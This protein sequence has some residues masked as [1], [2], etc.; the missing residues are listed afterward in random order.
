MLRRSEADSFI[1][2]PLVPS[3]PRGGSVSSR[4]SRQDHQLS[5][6]LPHHP[7]KLRD[8]APVVKPVHAVAWSMCIPR[9]LP[10][11]R[12]GGFHSPKPQRSILL[13]LFPFPF[14]W[15]YRADWA[16]KQ[17]D[18]ICCMANAASCVAAQRWERVQVGRTFQRSVRNLV[19]PKIAHQKLRPK[20][21][22]PCLDRS[23][24]CLQGQWGRAC[25]RGVRVE[26]SGRKFGME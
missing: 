19:S 13:R 3:P 18:V 15:R 7:H 4:G 21:H 6:A 8:K 5:W 20:A 11:V 24:R 12:V 9:K 26:F 14:P 17:P 2:A 22:S 16:A 10:P 25:I 1:W 23:R